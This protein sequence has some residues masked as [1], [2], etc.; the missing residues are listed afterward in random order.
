MKMSNKN[1]TAPKK[2]GNFLL[3]LD[4]EGFIVVIT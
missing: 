4:N 1:L 3:D 2:E